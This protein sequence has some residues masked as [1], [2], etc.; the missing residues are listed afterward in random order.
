MTRK[1][2]TDEDLRQAAEHVTYEMDLLVF[3]GSH[4]GGY[5]S[6]PMTRP[7]GSEE[8]V[9]LEAFLLHYRNL[10]AFLCPSLQRVSVDDILASDFLK[11]IDPIDIG[12]CHSLEGNNKVRL[13]RMLA[14]LSY[15]RGEFISSGQRGWHVQAMLADMLHEFN[16]F[17]KLLPLSL[18]VW[19]PPSEWLAVRETGARQFSDH[20]K[21]TPSPN[22]RLLPRDQLKGE[23][24]EHA[25]PPR[26]EEE[27]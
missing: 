5:H 19:F 9:M 20:Q 18:A 24:T 6:S 21:P 16:K 23:T 14:H 17:V 1:I 15:R 22:D 7:A 25:Y 8:N 27:G 13:D 12:D 26:Q 11:R 3:A 4:L 2:Q 10:R